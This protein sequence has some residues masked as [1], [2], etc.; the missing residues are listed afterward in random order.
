[1]VFGYTCP[2]RMHHGLMAPMAL[3]T[4]PLHFMSTVLFDQTSRSLSSHFVYVMRVL[5]VNIC[6]Y[7]SH[8]CYTKLNCSLWNAQTGMCKTNYDMHS[9]VT[10]CN[11]LL[12]PYTTVMAPTLHRSSDLD[13][14]AALIL[15]MLYW[16]FLRCIFYRQ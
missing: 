4:I 5:F 9:I 2:A 3:G 16:S 15:G 12:H 6:T 1:M 7:C 11:T 14:M 13:P 8:H 10:L